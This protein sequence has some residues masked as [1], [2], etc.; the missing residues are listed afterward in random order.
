MVDDEAVTPRYVQCLKPD[1][2]LSMIWRIA[3]G[4]LRNKILSGSGWVAMLW[5]GGESCGDDVRPI[6]I[7][8]VVRRSGA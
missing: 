8:C 6:A 7:T 1:R 5:V 2:E 4:S 3:K